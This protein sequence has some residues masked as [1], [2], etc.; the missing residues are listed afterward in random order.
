[1]HSMFGSRPTY[2]QEGTFSIGSRL[3]I[4]LSRQGSNRLRKNEV[5]ITDKPNRTLSANPTP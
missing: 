1:M 4:L 5:N 2:M 3:P